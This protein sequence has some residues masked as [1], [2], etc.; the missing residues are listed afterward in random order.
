MTKDFDKLLD[1]N[2]NDVMRIL[3]EGFKNG[4][5]I[6]ASLTPSFGLRAKINGST[7]SHFIIIALILIQTTENI[8]KDKESLKQFDV[9]DDMPEEIKKYM[10]FKTCLDEIENAYIG[11]SALND[12]AF[13]MFT[14]KTSEQAD[15]LEQ[16]FKM[17]K[18]DSKKFEDLVK[19]FTSKD[20]EKK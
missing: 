3:H 5:K 18:D 16:M 8:L 10:V 6:E 7:A 11:L 2:A 15:I 17:K 19:S 9:E 14:S 4:G 1:D 13:K 12:K 20:G